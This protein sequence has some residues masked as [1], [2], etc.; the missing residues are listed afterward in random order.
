MVDSVPHFQW[1]LEK[2]IGEREEGY[3]RRDQTVIDLITRNGTKDCCF[4]KAE[5]G[6]KD[7][8]LQKRDS[9]P[10]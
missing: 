2:D 6:S 1:D 10:R 5:V 8:Y 3:A 7:T 4:V 9:A